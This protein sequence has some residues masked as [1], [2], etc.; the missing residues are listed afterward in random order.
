MADVPLRLKKSRSAAVTVID[1]H[2]EEGRRLL[3]TARSVGTEGDFNEWAKDRERWIRL[4]LEGLMSVYT[5]AGPAKEL[6]GAS[7]PSAYLIGEDVNEQLQRD[8]ELVESAI[9][10]LDSLR[11]RLE[12]LEGPDD[13]SGLPAAAKTAPSGE[14]KIFLVHGHASDV[15]EAV[16]RF[17]EKTGEHE[18]VVLHEQPN[19]G[20]TLIEKFE[21][22]AGASDHAVVLLTADDLGGA[23]PEDGDDPALS[24]RGRQNVVFELGFFV[25]R[26][27]RSRAVVLYQE[28]VEIPSDFSGVVYIPLS[29]ESW[30]YKLLQEL[31]NA[32]L[33]FDLNKIPT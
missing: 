8:Y 20:R 31:R 30:R 18:V 16:T 32:G 19:E 27:G 33:N 7:Y 22:H 3:D 17:L 21:D 2:L 10:T 14:E 25:G 5:D 13:A 12:Y 11:E 29:D 15:K 6:Q 1:R 28:D 24:P 9:N 26:L 4:T 23:M